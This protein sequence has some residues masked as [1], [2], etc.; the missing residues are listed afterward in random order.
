MCNGSIPYHKCDVKS[1]KHLNSCRDLHIEYWTIECIVRTWHPPLSKLPDTGTGKINFWNTTS[2][3]GV[4]LSP[5]MEHAH[6][7]YFSQAVVGKTEEKNVCPA[8]AHT[9][10]LTLLLLLLLLSPFL[11][12]VISYNPILSF[13]SN[14]LYD[15]AI[16]QFIVHRLEYSCLLQLFSF[17]WLFF[18]WLVI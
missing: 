14:S 10:A 13:I 2:F 7:E 6:A 16:L 17:F 12:C 9:P 3:Y 11:S 15:G 18:A 1:F 8:P 4:D 5:A